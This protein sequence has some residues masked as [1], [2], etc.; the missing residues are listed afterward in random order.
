MS[1]RT[2]TVK[3]RCKLEYSLNYLVCRGDEEKRIL[4]DE[5]STLIIQNTGVSL[6][7]AL[8]SELVAK[9]V[10]VIFCDAKSNPQSE[11]VPYYGT[12]DSYAKITMQTSRSEEIKAKV[13]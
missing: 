13:L 1:F 7:A 2:I 6:T 10:K 12:Y 4:I 8:L 9:K 5:I 3:N 11:L